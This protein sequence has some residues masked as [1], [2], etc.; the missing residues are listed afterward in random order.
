M[1][2]PDGIRLDF[3][4]IGAVFDGFDPLS[5]ADESTRYFRMRPSSGE[6]AW[7]EYEFDSAKTVCVLMFL[8]PQHVCRL[9]LGE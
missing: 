4:D 9:A 7:L 2:R 8:L 1:A 6:P 3:D 5:S